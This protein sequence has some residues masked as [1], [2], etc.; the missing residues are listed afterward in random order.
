M[1]IDYRSLVLFAGEK[2]RL[3]PLDLSFTE[4]LYDAIDSSR[5]A[6]GVWLPW[7][8]PEYNRYQCRTWLESRQRARIDEESFDFAIT[9]AGNGELFG[10][11]G[12]DQIQASNRIG[13]L[14]FWVKTSVTGRGAASAGAA[15]VADFALNRL[16]L[17]RLEILVPELNRTAERVA[18]NIGARREVLLRNRLILHDQVHHVYLFSLLGSTEMPERPQESLWTRIS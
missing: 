7:C 16:H 15:A 17:I 1:D 9:D 8:T 11:C 14:Y 18:E 5:E 6:L 12:V 2:F 3:V 10:V 4:T 13:H